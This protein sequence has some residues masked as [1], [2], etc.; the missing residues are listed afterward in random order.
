MARH[1]TRAGYSLV[2]RPTTEAPARRVPVG[3][4][5]KMP[6]AEERKAIREF[7]T[8]SEGDT[9]GEGSYVVFVAYLLEGHFVAPRPSTAGEASGRTSTSTWRS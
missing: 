4:N 3:S 6:T 1:R 7:Y 9:I 8:T 5:A 2:I